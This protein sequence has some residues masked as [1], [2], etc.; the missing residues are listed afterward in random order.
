MNRIDI[1]ST[2]LHIR[3]YTQDDLESRY[4]L[5]TQAFESETTVELTQDWLTWTISSYQE[6]ARLYQPPYGDY[7]IELKDTG[8]VVGSVGIVQTVVPWG[9]FGDQ[10]PEEHHYLVSPEFGLFWAILPAHQRKGYASEAGKAVID[11]MFNE[12]HV[13]Q[14]VA[15]TDHDNLASQKTMTKLGMTLHHN[16]TGEPF[17]CE[18]VGVMKHPKISIVSP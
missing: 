10:T 1:H 6:L 5:T 7:A 17:W 14:V 8:E 13:Q 12:L 15:T 4:Q 9:V 18:V 11:H 3:H 16:T 2:R